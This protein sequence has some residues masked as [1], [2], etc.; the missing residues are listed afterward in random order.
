MF[1]DVCVNVYVWVSEGESNYKQMSTFNVH[2]MYTT[3]HL[4][5]LT[6]C[7][8]LSFALFFSLLFFSTRESKQHFTYFYL[9]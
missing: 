7:L 6:L 4:L 8:T 1:D 3:I 2:T 9:I 5:Y